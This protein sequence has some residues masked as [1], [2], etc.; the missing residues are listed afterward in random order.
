MLNNDFSQKKNKNF[1]ARSINY[2]FLKR[3]KFKKE[4]NG[5]LY[6]KIEFSDD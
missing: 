2:E 4:N 3:Q 1:D 5:N 6:L